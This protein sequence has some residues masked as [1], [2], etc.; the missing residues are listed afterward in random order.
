ITRCP[1]ACAAPTHAKLPPTDR[2]EL[3]KHVAAQ[4]AAHIARYSRRKVVSPSA[5]PPWVKDASESHGAPPQIDT[6]APQARSESA[7]EC[8]QEGE[9]SGE[10]LRAAAGTGQPPPVRTKDTESRYARFDVLRKANLRNRR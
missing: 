8:A 4:E 9:A 6:E 3:K 1:T 2:V 5:R 7:S 10:P